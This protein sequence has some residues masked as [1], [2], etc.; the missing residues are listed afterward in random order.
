V[1]AARPGD[2]ARGLA[3]ALL[4]ASCGLLLVVWG[5]DKLRDARHGLRV[6]AAF[7][8]GAVSSPA[9]MTLLGAAEVALGVAV[10][11]GLWRRVTYAA[12]LAITGATALAVWKSIVDP[13]GL[14]FAD[15][16]LLF[17]PSLIVFA[18]A[19]VLWTFR[20]DDTASLDA[21]AARR[22]G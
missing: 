6:A 22:R 17:H 16:Q 4:R 21:R 12:L 3:L 8:G 5:A 11:L 18:A 9:V 7:Y 19:L 2:R 10:A 15:A 13:L 20:D 1:T 14:V